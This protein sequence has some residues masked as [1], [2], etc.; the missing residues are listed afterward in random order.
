MT[1]VL[2]RPIPGISD[3]FRLETPV[4][5]P[6]LGYASASPSSRSRSRFSG[7]HR[8]A[9][10]LPRRPRTGAASERRG[11]RTRPPTAGAGRRRP[12]GDGVVGPACRRMHQLPSLPRR[13]WR[14]YSLV[15]IV[16]DIHQPTLATIDPYRVDFEP[17]LVDAAVF[18]QDA[19]DHVQSIATCGLEAANI[20]V[21][22]A[23]GSGVTFESVVH[24][25]SRRRP[26]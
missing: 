19:R 15:L 17:A 4:S 7:T 18:D 14:R 1:G 25:R 23:G 22:V 8:C 26:Y 12:Y 20:C 10:R 16:P 9:V 5:A 6:L 3:L 24:V 2:P 11:R 21:L 13:N